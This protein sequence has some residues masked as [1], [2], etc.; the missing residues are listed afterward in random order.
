MNPLYLGNACN[1]NPLYLGT[2]CHVNPLYL[3]DACHV[4]RLYFKATKWRHVKGRLNDVLK[5]AQNILIRDA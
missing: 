3:G 1:F 5:D 4:N 2:A